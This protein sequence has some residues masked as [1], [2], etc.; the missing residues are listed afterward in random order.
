MQQTAMLEQ[1][2]P[3][4]EKLVENALQLLSQLHNLLQEES[5]ALV[6]LKSPET[7]GAIAQAK[8][9]LVSQL[10]LFNTHCGQLLATEQLSNNQQ[11]LDEYFQRAET[12][13][14]LTQELTD[15]WAT[16]IALS[17]QCR[18]LNEQNGTSIAILSRHNERLLQILKGKPDT[19]HTYGPD[20]S[21]RSELYTRT[22]ISV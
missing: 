5:V 14:L 20:G 21:K 11:G 10:E 15:H 13:G 17:Q 2:Y 12:A 4:L 16:I 1:T 18:T 3:I 8:K 22:L 7:I 9:Q 19:A 6:N